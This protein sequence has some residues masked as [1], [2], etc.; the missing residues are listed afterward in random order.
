VKGGPGIQREN[1]EKIS[2]KF[3]TNAIAPS[4]IIGETKDGTGKK[5]EA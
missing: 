2:A 4:S 3:G 5:R 1:F